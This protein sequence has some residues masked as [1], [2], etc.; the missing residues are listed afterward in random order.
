VIVSISIQYSGTRK[1]NNS[2]KLLGAKR[3]NLKEVNPN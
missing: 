2:K 3:E 1:A